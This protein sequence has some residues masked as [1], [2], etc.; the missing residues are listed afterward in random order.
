MVNSVG[1]V[2]EFD[3]DSTVPV[4]EVVQPTPEAEEIIE[5]A[6]EGTETP[7]VPPPAIEP[8]VDD[9]LVKQVEGLA[10]E[11]AL[12]LEEIKSLRG[13]KREIKQE[14][15]HRVD[16]QIDSSLT[17]VN[18]DDVTVIEKVLRAKGLITKEEAQGMFYESVKQE[19][20]G[21]FLER[22]PEYKPENDPNN[23]NWN[24]LNREIEIFRR[25]DDPRQL[26]SILERA[27]KNIAKAPTTNVQVQRQR[28]S[29]AGLGSGGVQR[30]VSTASRSKVT[31]EME[32][33]YRQGG[34]TDEDI[35]KLKGK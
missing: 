20:I 30:T 12:L 6:P 14:Q 16:Q 15:I 4:E 26:A 7:A 17:D 3:S 29:V 24:A 27:H 5:S 9:V 11:K 33:R 13:D 10:R 28:V 23:I 32:E 25:P 34:W 1:T 35:A 18:P 22:Y 31:P 2:P 19:E 21:K 8:P